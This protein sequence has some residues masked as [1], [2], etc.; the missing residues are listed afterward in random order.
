M[1]SVTLQ[2]ANDVTKKCRVIPL[3]WI[4]CDDGHRCDGDIRLE[5]VVGGALGRRLRQAY[6]KER[7]SW[8]NL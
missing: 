5:T 7:K 2:N 1:L 8:F 4:S 6:R 3:N